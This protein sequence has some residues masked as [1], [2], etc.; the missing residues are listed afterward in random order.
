MTDTRITP[1][2]YQSTRMQYRLSEPAIILPTWKALLRIDEDRDELWL[3]P[4]PFTFLVTMKNGYQYRFHFKRGFIW[5]KISKA[6]RNNV[7]AG[8]IP[9][10]GHDY[11]YSCHPFGEN[12]KAMT[13]T[14]R[15]FYHMLRYYG[16]SWFRAGLWYLAVNS[17]P[18]RAIYQKN[19]RA[20]WHQATSDF[21]EGRGLEL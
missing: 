4:T 9:A 20:W 7:L 11:M 1:W 13:K 8:E 2:G 6:G 14:N 17:I 10:M 16:M 12:G 21:S 15:L 18:G 3:R 19:N 5:D